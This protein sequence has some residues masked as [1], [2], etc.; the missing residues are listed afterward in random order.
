MQGDINK[1]IEENLG[2]VYKQLHKFYLAY[3]HE[4]ESLAYEAL[5]KAIV[6]FDETRGTALST[7]A[8]VYIYNTLGN[9]VRLLKR[10]RQI[11]TVSYNSLVAETGDEYVELLALTVDTEKEYIQTE[12]MHTV[13]EVFNEQYAKLKGEKVRRIIA[14]WQKS[15]YSATLTDIAHEVGVSQSYAS[16]VVT[17]F[18]ATLRKKL[19]GEYYD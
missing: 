10:K 6:D 13:N 11:Q 19:K 7:L 16:Q 17:N 3:D 1:L 9:Y 4:A 12:L 2:L 14:L 8:T 18:K 15:E 5:Y